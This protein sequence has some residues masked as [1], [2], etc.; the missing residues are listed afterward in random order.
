MSCSVPLREKFGYWARVWVLGGAAIAGTIASSAE[1]VAVVTRVEGEV[2]LLVEPEAQEA[3][4]TAGSLVVFEGTKY[5]ATAAK[6][7]D[8]VGRGN[9]L[10]T[11]PK[12]KARVIYKNGD[13]FTVGPATAYKI[14][15]D[16]AKGDKPLLQLFYGKVRALVEKDGPRTGLEVR[17]KSAV[18]GVRGTDFHAQAW[19]KSG[20]S[21]VSVLR[22]AV[23]VRDAK[24]PEAKPVTVETGFSAVLRPAAPAAAGNAGQATAPALQLKPTSREQLVVIQHVSK[25][26]KATVTTGQPET[27][28]IEVQALEKQATN[29]ALA[30]IKKQDPALFAAL[31]AAKDGV[32]TDAIQAQTVKKQ[33]LT[34]PSRSHSARKPR[35]EDLDSTT[36][37]YDA[38]GW[39]ED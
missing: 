38:Y 39:D 25:V 7:G 26:A 19:S 12:S 21:E 34:A 35:P 18:M 31:A 1:Q 15:W 33:F 9:V 13:Q 37:V 17:T 29:T 28:A 30:D 36:D 23:A 3:G 4:S 16:E 6:V 24:A 8:H 14:T 27:V 5:R 22:G 20:G 11:D 10:Q 32:D 2:K